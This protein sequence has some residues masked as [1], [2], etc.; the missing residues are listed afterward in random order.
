MGQGDV[1]QNVHRLSPY[2]D[3][4]DPKP[5][6]ITNGFVSMVCQVAGGPG[7]KRRDPLLLQFHTSAFHLGSSILKAAVFEL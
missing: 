4:T 6:W 3:A 7:L 2:R 1:I 5:V